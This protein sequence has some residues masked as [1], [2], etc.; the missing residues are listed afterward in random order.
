MLKFLLFTTLICLAGT[1]PAGA[2]NI[3]QSSDTPPPVLPFGREKILALDS[4][5]EA[6]TLTRDNLDSALFYADSLK[7]IGRMIGMEGEG[8]ALAEKHYGV[9]NRHRGKYNEALENISYYLQHLGTDTSSFHFAEGNYQLGVIYQFRGNYIKSLEAYQHAY[10]GFYA[11]GNHSYAAHTLVGIGSIYKTQKRWDQARSTYEKALEIFEDLDD[12]NAV[13]VTLSNLGDVFVGIEGYSH[14]E[15]FYRRSLAISIELNQDWHVADDYDDLGDMLRF[16]EK[17]PEALAEYFKALP[18]RRKNGNPMSAAQTLLNIGITH[19]KMKQ[20]RSAEKY[21]A[22]GLQLAAE[23]DATPVLEDL[24]KYMSEVYAER[25]HFEKA[26]EYHHNYVTVRD[27]LMGRDVEKQLNELQIMYETNEKDNQIALMAKEKELHEQEMMRQRATQKFYIFAFIAALITGILV[28]YVYRQRLRNQKSIALK[29]EEL[30]RE[31]FRNELRELEM[32]ALRAQINPHFI[33]NCMNSID[34][35][36]LSGNTGD[37]SVY[38]GKLSI[39]IRLILENSEASEVM[40]SSELRL[41]KAYI[42]LEQLRFKNA[43]DY[44]C[45][46]SPQL[47]PDEIYIPPMILQPFLEN[48]IWHGLNHKKGEER[49]SILLSVDYSE[50]ALIFKIED[51]GVG[52][53]HSNQLKKQRT[54]KQS[55]MGLKITEDRLRLITRNNSTPI[56]RFEDLR[57]PD[58]APCGTRVLIELSNYPD[59]A[60]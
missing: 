33:F 6:I 2:Q 29:N 45:L 23:A 60:V 27:S 35:L 37:A 58:G 34:Q 15:D 12:K 14:A 26:L 57:K 10:N 44:H 1:C 54:V 16:Q 52:R 39:M 24:Y 38:L 28:Y 48:A 32:K 13:G 22:E 55:S 19:V 36:I 59:I 40:L 17:Y 53:E 11:Q 47:D 51:N 50:D 20:F 3:A 42:E 43:I 46:V 56:I 31:K 30:N 8:T 41:M 18:I 49:G 21:L 7:I 25:K 5:C 4:V 9:V